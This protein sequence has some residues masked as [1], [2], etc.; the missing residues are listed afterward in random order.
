[1]LSP[2]VESPLS[3]NGI[4]T[5]AEPLVLPPLAALELYRVGFVLSA[6]NHKLT[7]CTWGATVESTSAPSVSL[8][9]RNA[10]FRVPVPHWVGFAAVQTGATL[11][12]AV[13]VWL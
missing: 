13:A 8:D 12:R 4:A 10:P 5:D 1:M 3:N 6:L 9:S 7:D 2:A 11:T